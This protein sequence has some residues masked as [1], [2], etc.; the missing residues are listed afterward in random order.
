MHLALKMNV[1]MTNEKMREEFEKWFWSYHHGDYPMEYW[2]VVFASGSD[3]KYQGIACEAG[4]QAWQAANKTSVPDWYCVV[5]VEP[6]SGMLIAASGACHC[7][8]YWKPAY[9]AMLDEGMIK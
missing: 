9:K 6:T 3:G 1:K 4:W 2:Q 7:A 8:T 5:P